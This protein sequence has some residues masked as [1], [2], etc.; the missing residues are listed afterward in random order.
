MVT[1]CPKCGNKE[2]K[3]VNAGY[4][5]C[6]TDEGRYG[7][8]MSCSHDAQKCTKCGTIFTIWDESDEE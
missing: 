8:D 3:D 5:G 6:C 4:D 1:K 7:R 2:L